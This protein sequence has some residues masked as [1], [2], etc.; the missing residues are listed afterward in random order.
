MNATSFLRL[1]DNV[2]LFLVKS[3]SSNEELVSQ[4]RLVLASFLRVEH[5]DDEV[6]G[7]SH[8][9][10]LATTTLALSGAFNNSWQIKQLQ[11]RSVD[12]QLAWNAGQ[13]CELVSCNCT[14]LRSHQV[15]EG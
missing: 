6:C 10:D 5:H 14:V 7:L 9:N 12:E 1:D 4:L 13:S 8:C 11:L 2:G 3:D 15:Q